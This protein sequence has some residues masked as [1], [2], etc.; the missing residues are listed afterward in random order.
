[1]ERV[2]YGVAVGRR[3]DIVLLLQ[4]E[5]P[6]SLAKLRSSL[7]I[8]ASTLLFELSALESLGVIRRED[9]LVYLTELG[10]KVA[11]II[12]TME[13]LKSLN[14][15]SVVGLRP[16]VVWLLMSPFLH[17]AASV[18]LM[19]WVAALMFGALQNPPL[20]YSASRMWGTTYPSL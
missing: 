11:S 13:P 17:I 10:E 4:R 8:S 15:L 19:G 18:L 20:G 12:S 16:L 6:L 7:G 2:I 3:R 14:F 1:V 9:S 5:G